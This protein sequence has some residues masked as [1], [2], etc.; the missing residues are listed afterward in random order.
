MAILRIKD[1]EQRSVFEVIGFLEYFSDNPDNS[2][3]QNRLNP[4][5][6]RTAANADFLSKQASIAISPCYSM[7]FGV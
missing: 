1:S 4:P 3:E 2:I 5:S 7:S 6:Q